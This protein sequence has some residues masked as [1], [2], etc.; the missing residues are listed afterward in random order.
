MIVNSS[1]SIRRH[2]VAAVEFAFMMALFLPFILFGLFE[3]GRIVM[4][5]NILDNAARDGGRM[6]ASGSFYAS[7]NNLAPPSVYNGNSSTTTLSLSSPSR[8]PSSPPSG[9]YF[10]TQI[11]VLNYLT[12]AGL[13]TTGTTVTVNN[14]TE[15]WSYSYTGGG[16]GSGSG[17]DPAAAAFQADP[18]N[19][20][21]QADQITTSLQVTYASISW[22]PTNYYVSPTT[23]LSASSTWYT[24]RDVPVLLSTSPLSAPLAAGAS[25]P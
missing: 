4:V 13:S 18:A 22:S 14:T 17:Y 11:H 24:N 16:S 19:G 10:E 8:G 25:I 15:G 6:A 2:G 3:V 5:Q 9:G 23:Q 1:Q 12:A 20:I 21:N 7:N